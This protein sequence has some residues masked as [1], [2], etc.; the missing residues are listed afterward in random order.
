[1]D[2]KHKMKRKVKVREKR[3]NLGPF[4]ILGIILIL[5]MGVF[6]TFASAYFTSR[7]ILLIKHSPYFYVKKI[8]ITGARMTPESK[9][10]E[11]IKNGK[12]NLNI[13]EVDLT[14][15]RNTILGENWIKDVRVRR[16]FP[17]T[18]SVEVQER[19]PVAR[20]RL[21]DGEYLVDEDGFI[22]LKVNGKFKEFPLVLG[23]INREDLSSVKNI[24]E[25]YKEVSG[26]YPKEIVFH[27]S[28]IRI[29]DLSGILLIFDRKEMENMKYVKWTFEYIRSKG[30]SPITVDMTYPKKA[31]LQF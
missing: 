18:I 29:T 7:G 19:T 8:K 11:I 1:M 3:I 9:I 14:K 26:S 13:F 6:A 2:R 30:I 27:N 31:V 5:T 4:K 24:I 12:N 15:V 21:A 20:I 25:E 10:I 16:I 22:F 17:D 28:R 23:E